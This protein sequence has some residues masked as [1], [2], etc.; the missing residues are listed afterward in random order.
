M[1][2]AVWRRLIE[3]STIVRIA[4]A[5][6]VVFFVSFL[7]T[8]ASPPSWFLT[9]LALWFLFC[10][11]GFH[12]YFGAATALTPTRVRLIDYVY[13]GVGAFGVFVLTMGYENRRDAYFHAMEI[14]KIE[15]D[16]VAARRELI[17]DAIAIE[18]EA[19]KVNVVN[20]MPSYCEAAKKLRASFERNP[21]FEEIEAAVAQYRE[22]AKPPS[23]LDV[24]R[25]IAYQKLERLTLFLGMGA[26][27]AKIDKLFLEALGP[28]EADPHKEAFG[29]FT[30]P[31]ILAFALGLRITRTT[32][33]VLDWT[34]RATP[35][36]SAANELPSL[37]RIDTPLPSWIERK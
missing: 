27:S 28:P 2:V 7:L 15:Q 34:A 1:A 12:W 13:L 21:T 14:E 37:P 8:I 32:I 6:T 11:S 24:E 20:L 19:C 22:V 35:P 5:S 10:L 31:F 3:R 23:P 29:L 9:K 36:I 16:A 26:R 25:T 30:W 18:G 33:E 4:R 17:G